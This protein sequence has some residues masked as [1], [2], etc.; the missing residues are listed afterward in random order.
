LSFNG[1]PVLVRGQASLASSKAY[2]ENGEQVVEFSYNGNMKYAKWKI[3]AS[4]WTTL[5]YEYSI[6]G[7]EPFFRN[8]FQ[9][10]RKLYS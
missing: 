10:S 9:L 6:E 2:I 5:E 4:G 3:N 8:Q 7:D 1:G